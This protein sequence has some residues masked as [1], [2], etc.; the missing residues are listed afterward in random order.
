[1]NHRE[2]DS[3]LK[4]E[5][6]SYD[7]AFFIYGTLRE[8]F[9]EYVLK[10]FAKFIGEGYISSTLYDLKYYPGAVYRYIELIKYAVKLSP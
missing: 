9:E 4:F 10:G 3:S 7:T 5:D 6:A 2:R 1:M 8:K